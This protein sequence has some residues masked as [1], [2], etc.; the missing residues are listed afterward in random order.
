MLLVRRLYPLVDFPSLTSPLETEMK[1]TERKKIKSVS[2]VKL[3]NKRSQ[4]YELSSTPAYV[5]PFAQQEW[6]F[7]KGISIK[8]ALLTLAL[9]LTV[10]D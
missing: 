6:S 2:I 5:E 9:F 7:R 1:K 3:F 8:E 4:D 10:F